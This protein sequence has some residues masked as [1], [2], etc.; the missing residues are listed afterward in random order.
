MSA[1]YRALPAVDALLRHPALAAAEPGE[2][3]LLLAAARRVLAEARAAIAAGGEPPAAEALAARA[4]VMAAAERRPRLRPLIN[5]SGVVLQTNLG[6]APLSGAAL[7]AVAAVAAGYS[8]LEFDLEAGRRGSRQAALGPLLAAVTGA[9]A[10]LAVNNNAAE[11]LLALA[12]LAA[13]REVPVSRG[14]L[15]EIGGGFRIP[16]VLAQSGARLVEVGTTNRTYARDYEAAIG[17]ATAAILRVHPSNFVLR[18]FV[19]QPAPAELAALAHARGLL[20]IDDLGSGA[21]LDTAAYGLAHEPTVQESLAAG[22]DLVCFS[23]DKLLGG[24][25]AGLVAGAAEAV[26]ALARHPLARAVRID[27]LSL[28]ALE[29]TLRHYLLGEAEQAVPVWRM[30]G[31]PVAELAAQAGQWAARLASAG[32]AAEAVPGESTVGG[33]SLPGETLPTTL[34]AL[35]APDVEALAR[36]LRAG[37]PAVVG[38]IQRD[39]LLLDPRTVLPGQE[40]ALLAALMEDA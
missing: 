15:V 24:P 21:L 4:A 26:A 39:T 35:R 25:Q 12:A 1:G 38:R 20:L 32:L 14:Q 23:G 6:R 10:G 18:G 29:A 8:N 27:K 33:G 7:T 30:L 36:R 16:D 22:A 9:P 13:G 37:T 19:H 17:P 11:V 31:R 5:A 40:E 3:E 28:A 34:V 2:R